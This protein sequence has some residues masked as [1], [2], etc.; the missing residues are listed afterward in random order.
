MLKHKKSTENNS[1]REIEA[2][3]QKKEEKKLNVKQRSSELKICHSSI[4]FLKYLNLHLQMLRLWRRTY[5]ELIKIYFILFF[6]LCFYKSFHKD[7]NYPPV[8]LKECKYIE[9]KVIRHINNICV[10]LL[11]LQN[12][13]YGN[14]VTDFRSEKI[15]RWTLIILA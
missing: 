12:K 11:L 5:D 1:D 14:G 13:I 3:K 8:F 4:I 2:S 15:Q 6:Y 7:D 9:K 10:I